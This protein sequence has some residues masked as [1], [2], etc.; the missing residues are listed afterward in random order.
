MIRHSDIAIAE[1][2]ID[3]S[4][5]VQILLDGR[6]RSNRGRKTD[7]KPYRLLLIGGL[8]NIQAQRTFVISDIYDTLT[9]AIPFDEQYR[10]GVREHRIDPE[11]GERYVHV[12][13]LHDLHNAIAALRTHLSYGTASG[14]G[15]TDAEKGR[16]RKVIRD[17]CDA[18]LDVFDRGWTSNTYAMDATG[19]WSWGR[20]KAKTPA[21]ADDDPDE[22]APA[23]A[24][25]AA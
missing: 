25:S 14:A 12:L 13:R 22:P 23:E 17:F 20:G 7:P 24:P 5:A 1:H 9:A 16:R 2:I 18:L 21:P 15:L 3:T 6:K 10:L 11:T 4:G 8:L 19:I